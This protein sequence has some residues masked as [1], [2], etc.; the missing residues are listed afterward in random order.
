MQPE[1]LLTLII[2]CRAETRGITEEWKKNKERESRW[3]QLG[4]VMI[5]STVLDT[6]RSGRQRVDKSV[7]RVVGNQL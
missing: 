7:G 2:I 1:A 6:A 5:G 4:S 3:K